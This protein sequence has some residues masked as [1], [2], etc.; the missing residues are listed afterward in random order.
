MEPVGEEAI[1]SELAA[2]SAT[3][4]KADVSRRLLTYLVECHLRAKVP[5]ETDIALDVFHRDAGFDGAQDAVVRVAVRALRQKLDEFY[6]S[7][8]RGRPLRLEVP[9]GAYRISVLPVATAAAE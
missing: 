5:K 7:A 9:R 6:H 3:F 1:R 4:G 8:G 2:I